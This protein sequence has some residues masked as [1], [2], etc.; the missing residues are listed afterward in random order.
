MLVSLPLKGPWDM[1]LQTHV[2]TVIYTGKLKR[3]GS[4]WRRVTNAGK[5]EQCMLPNC[6]HFCLWIN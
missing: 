6:E 3:R 4:Y 2:H 1:C 5:M